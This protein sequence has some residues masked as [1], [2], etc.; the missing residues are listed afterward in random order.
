MRKSFLGLFALLFMGISLH[1]QS[2]VDGFKEA[3][4]L[5]SKYSLEEDA[6]KKAD[7]LDNAKQ[8]IDIAS[9]GIQSIEAKDL[10]KL[11]TLKGEIYNNMAK[12]DSNMSYINPEHKAKY[13]EAASTAY[14]AYQKALGLA[15]KKWQ[16][17]DALNNILSTAGSMTNAGRVMYTEKNYKGALNIFE[18]AIA[19]KELLVENGENGFLAT[20]EEMN[21]HLFMTALSASISQNNEAASKYFGKLYDAKYD[22][23]AIY[24]GYFRALK[25]TDKDKAVEVLAKGR[26]MYPE[27]EGLL[28]AEINYYLAEQK[29]DVLVERLKSAIE[30]DPENTTYVST[31]GNV[32]DNLS[33]RETEANNSAKSTEYFNLALEYYNKALEMDPNYHTALYNAGT[34]YYNKA[35]LLTKEMV[36]LSSDYSKAGTA[37]YDA[38]KVEVFSNFDQALPYFQKAEVIDPNDIGTLTALKEIYAKKDD[39]EKSG[40]FKTRLETVRR[41]GK[42]EAFHKM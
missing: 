13:P 25:D 38:K 37:K 3:K 22:N 12:T 11:W 34:L 20:D 1:A 39:L 14:E 23:A 4:K 9:A 24:D 18:K 26:E 33:Q 41:G 17:S 42:N 36:E 21:D 10:Y 8:N 40:E 15:E 16:K 31:L 30:K 32:Y 27:D 7:Y 2:P 6:T 5:L 35:A 19:A 29:L 28:I